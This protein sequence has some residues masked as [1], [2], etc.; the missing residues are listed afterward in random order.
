MRTHKLLLSAVDIIFLLQDP[1]ISMKA[2]DDLLHLFPHSS[3][4]KVNFSKAVIMGLN[5]NSEF[6]KEVAAITAAAWTSCI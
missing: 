3:G 1:V 5:M 6:K 4:Y 2:L